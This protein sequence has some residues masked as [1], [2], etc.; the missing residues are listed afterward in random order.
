M[1]EETR[2]TRGSQITLTK[3]VREK[4]GIK[5]GDKVVLHLSGNVLIVSKKDSSVFDDFRSFL[6]ERFES[7]L[8]KTRSDEKERL[9]KLGIIE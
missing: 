7:Y 1:S 6:P 8:K 4:L 9:K 5:E 2:V 3:A